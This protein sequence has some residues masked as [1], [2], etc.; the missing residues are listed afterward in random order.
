MECQGTSKNLRLPKT[1]FMVRAIMLIHRVKLFTMNKYILFLCYT[2]TLNS[3]DRV[4]GLGRRTESYTKVREGPREPFSHFLQRLTKAVQI[5][6]TDPEPR[7]VFII[8]LALEHA[9]LECKRIL[10]SLKVRSAPIDE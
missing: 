7:L 10:R 1:K 3:W 8:S 6:A 9:N 4:Q 2:A 5:A